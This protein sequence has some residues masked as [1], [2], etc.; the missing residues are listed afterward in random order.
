MGNNRA[1]RRQ[2][3]MRRT[4]DFRGEPVTPTDG[5]LRNC[6][7]FFEFYCPGDTRARDERYVAD[8][9]NPSLQ[10][11]LKVVIARLEIHDARFHR[12][13]VA[14]RTQHIWST[15]SLIAHASCQEALQ[16]STSIK[17]MIKVLEKL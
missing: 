3:A 8:G 7:F 15:M 2:K 6:V 1:K 5:D 10:G 12:P 17:P 9:H 16:A 13:A 4:G 14:D 11:F